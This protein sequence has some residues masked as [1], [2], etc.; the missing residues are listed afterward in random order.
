MTIASRGLKIKVR[1]ERLHERH[2]STC[3][4]DC[5]FF[6]RALQMQPQPTFL[7]VAANGIHSDDSD[8]DVSKSSASVSS[9]MHGSRHVDSG[10]Q[11]QQQQQQQLTADLSQSI[12]APTTSTPILSRT[13]PD[14][15]SCPIDASWRDIQNGSLLGISDGPA[16]TVSDVQKQNGVNDSYT[17]PTESSLKHHMHDASDSLPLENEVFVIE[18]HPVKFRG[19]GPTDTETGIP[20]AS[21]TVS[22]TSLTWFY[23]RTCFC[24][25]L[26]AALL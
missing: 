7:A 16:T 14:E 2:R 1:V 17:I 11:E 21:R 23:F 25:F 19:I 5:T 24:N 6:S 22:K 18:K 3:R 13:E 20:I 4:Q 8:D 26:S 15:L 9:E 10:I 12:N